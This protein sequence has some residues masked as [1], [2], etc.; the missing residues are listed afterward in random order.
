MRKKL[1]YL[2]IAALLYVAIT[3]TVQKLSC[4]SMTETQLFL[5]LGETL[6]L[7]FKHCP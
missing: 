6:V 7:N 4:P 2:L 3:N 1:W 5:H